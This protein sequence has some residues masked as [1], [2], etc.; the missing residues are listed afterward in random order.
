MVAVQQHH[1]AVQSTGQDSQRTFVQ[2]IYKM[3]KKKKMQKNRKKETATHLNQQ[4]HQTIAP[5]SVP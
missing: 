2:F 5:P 4:K 1:Q 3:Q